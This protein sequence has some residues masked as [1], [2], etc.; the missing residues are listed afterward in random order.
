GSGAE[1]IPVVALDGRE[2]G[3][4]QPGPVTA[5]LLAAFRQRVAREGVKI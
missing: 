4:G 1:V 3:S 5:R 2:I